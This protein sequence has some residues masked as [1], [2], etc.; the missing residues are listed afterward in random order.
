MV[1]EKALQKFEQLKTRILFFFDE[2]K[3]YTDEFLNYE[4]E[5]FKVIE[6]DKNYF[7]AK[8]QIEIE[9]ENRD[10][11]FLLYHTFGRPKKKDYKE[12][13]LIDLLYA[14]QELLIDETADILDQYRIDQRYAPLLKK[15]KRFV[16]SKKY[17]KGILP[18]LSAQSFYTKDFYNA[19][20]SFVLDEKRVGKRN[21]NLIRIFEILQNGEKEWENFLS[22]LKRE[23]LVDAVLTAIY[24]E[25]LIR[26]EDIEFDT[27]KSLFLKLKYNAITHYIPKADPD[28]RYAKLKIND[29]SVL[30][31]I[32]FLFKDWRDAKDKEASLPEVLAGLGAD[33]N[34]QKIIEVYGMDKTYG[35]E[36]DA[37]N[38]FKLQQALEKIN[39]EPDWVIE[40]LAMWE[41][42]PDKF[43]S[44][45]F[46]LTFIL[47][48]AKFYAL[49][50]NYSDFDFNYPESY[51]E[52]YE[53]EL[54]QLDLNYRKAF[55]AYQNLIKE[56]SPLLYE[57]AYT[58]LNKDY[59]QFVIDL[60]NGWMRIL[61]E[62]NFDLRNIKVPKQYNFY[63]DFATGDTKKVVIIS[64]AFRYELATDLVESLKKDPV[65]DIQ[66]KPVLAS[67]PSYTNLGMSNLLPNNGIE[68]IKTSNSIDYAINGIPTG[69]LENRTKIL[70]QNEESTDAIQ[71]ADFM[72]L[73]IEGQ[74]GILKGN[75]ILYIYHNWMDSVG[76]Q[77][78]S[79]YY[80]F[81]SAENCVTQLEGLINRLYRSLN[82]YNIIVTADH[83]F[84]FN[85]N[86]LKESDRQPAPELDS[87]LK[88]HTR[89]YITE[90]KTKVKDSFVFPLAYTSNIISEEQ[91]VIPKSINRYRK[92]GGFGV[93]FVHGG[94]SLQEI[95]VPVLELYRDRGGKSVPVS[96]RRLDDLKT[97]SSS[98][99]NF[100]ILQDEP[101]EKGREAIAIVVGIYDLDDQLIT[102]EVHLTLDATD[103]NPS[104]RVYEFR[105]E[106][107]SLGAKAN[108]GYLRAFRES[109]TERL[110]VLHINDLIRIITLNDEIDEF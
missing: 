76:D 81:E 42:H 92:K 97:I 14:N 54:Y 101:V 43:E 107:N 96:F 84:L 3:E 67:I 7:W 36:T 51:I 98:A 70:Q 30:N 99:A 45:Y 34:E 31:R 2:E 41:N 93:Q 38:L 103:K 39:S 11:R 100:K 71:Y 53:K 90:D 19:I 56:E 61:A 75:R 106:L 47:S 26:V 25:T 16:K 40:K 15:Y 57:T 65:N 74:R 20:I 44:Y 6:I 29:E 60:N 33:V 9:I 66:L 64:D 110:N 46:P 50:R 13:A 78:S 94:S 22:K 63:R 10:K 17:Q 32:E 73:S 4:G 55:T 21:F 62:K 95:I 77:R 23:E 59:D 102:N 49:L 89:F 58:T 109:D 35:L 86:E 28:D 108:N 79:E 27:L 105:L 68:T 52:K 91:V 18:V 72:R 83:G 104:G 1:I 80:T 24:D 12:Y 88:E 87:V 82:T 37:F 69:G 5:E 85:H 48:A 8:H